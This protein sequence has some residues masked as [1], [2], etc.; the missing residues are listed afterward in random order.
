MRPTLLG[1]LLPEESRTNAPT[2]QVN[3][4]LLGA[5]E[6]TTANQGDCRFQYPDPNAAG[7]LN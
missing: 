5:K 7:R 3:A 6:R 2:S 1:S 4:K